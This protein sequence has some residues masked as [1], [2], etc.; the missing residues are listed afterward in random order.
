MSA[1]IPEWLAILRRECEG[2]SIASVARELGYARTSVSLAVSGRYGG[3][4]QRIAARVMEVF[5]GPIICP[6]LRGPI[7]RSACADRRNGPMPTNAA[8]DL[9]HW[10]ACRSCPVMTG[11]NKPERSQNG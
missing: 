4:Q 8:S 10:M 1:R 9:K 3:T 5:G 2:R 7:S 6:H 11:R